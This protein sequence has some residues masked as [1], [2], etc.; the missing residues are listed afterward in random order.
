MLFSFKNQNYIHLNG[1]FVLKLKYLDVNDSLPF[2]LFL[3]NFHK[4]KEKIIGLK[5]HICHSLPSITDALSKKYFPSCFAVH[6]LLSR[7]NIVI[8]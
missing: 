8:L 4:K 6:H 1:V 3:F 2:L 7:N 5:G